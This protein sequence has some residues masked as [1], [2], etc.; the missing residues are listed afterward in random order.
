M[1]LLEYCRLSG[2]KQFFLA[3]TGGVYEG[4]S[5]PISEAG[6][7]IPPSD[8]GFY[9]AS[10]LAS[11]MFSA[12]YRQV[13]DVTV[14]RFFFMFGPRQRSDMFLPRLVKKVLSGE[15]VQVSHR[16]GIRV[17]PIDVDDVANVLSILLGGAAPTVVNVGGDDI[18][19]VREIAE[20]IGRNTSRTP[21]FENSAESSDIIA[22]IS[23][24]KRATNNYVMTPF[25]DGLARLTASI[26][27][28]G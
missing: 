3:S 25:Y 5:G 19:S 23:E 20:E 26:Q 17:N 24:L 15:P 14:L 9:F 21:I 13:F 12:T 18:V 2:G 4:Q 10:K 22:D 6:G 27:A 1:E 8:I 28:S 11:E 16:G 7:L